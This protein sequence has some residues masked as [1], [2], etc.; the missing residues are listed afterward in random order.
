MD[1]RA[2]PERVWQAMT[3]PTLTRQY[4]YGTDILSDW[5]AGSRW[6]S[7]SGGHVSLEGRILEVDPPRRLVQTFRVTD[8]DPAA[9]ED[10]ST[11]T[12]DLAPLPD[13]AGTRLHLVHAD[14]G[15]ATL[16]YTEGGWE[17][18]LAGLKELLEGD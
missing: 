9:S 4:F 18:I 6:T 10:P 12:W 5:Q 16:A 2:T 11:V 13:G 7:E 15:E 3:D 1:I 17:H 8:D 14:Q